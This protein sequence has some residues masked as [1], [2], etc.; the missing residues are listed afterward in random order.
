[1]ASGMKSQDMEAAGRDRTTLIALFLIVVVLAIAVG[2]LAWWLRREQDRPLFSEGGV[3][4]AIAPLHPDVMAP[5]PHEAPA[6]AAKAVAAPAK[7][8]TLT[9][10]MAPKPAGTAKTA[11]KSAK[12]APTETAVAPLANAIVLKPAPAD[13]A[14]TS[15]GNA[16]ALISAPDP[17]LIEHGKYGF[18]PVVGH[19]GRL[20]WQVYARPFDLSDPRPRIA[21]VVTGLGIG[22]TATDAAINRLPPEVTLAFAPF[23]P[24]ISEWTNLAR[25]AGHE[26]L[27]EVPMEPVDYPRQD[28]GY[29]ALL[30][31]YDAPE[32]L[33]RLEWAM[34]QT[35]GYVGIIG[36]M[37][38]RFQA[39]HDSLAPVLKEIATRGLLYVDNHTTAA[40]AV[41]SIAAGDRLPL[42][43]ANR[44]IDAEPA[45][46]A[47]DRNLADLEDIAK[48]D[49]VALGLVSAEPVSLDS[50]S[51]WA[52]GL[53]ARG[54][55]LAPVSAIV[56]VPQPSAQN[57]QPTQ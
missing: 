17:G 49:H 56:A 46:A 57:G 5:M 51:D 43:E 36:R 50:I 48:R 31:A 30:T 42:A 6:Q 24:R 3:S 53:A 13:A 32:N 52:A 18:L 14:P 22:S 26:V 41:S 21:I 35:V 55:A 15:A 12:P 28:P 1:M 27:L 8:A 23:S 33:D 20:P 47:L 34:S 25:V 40:S 4:V 19:D 45:R 37:G 9:A 10:A 16:H 38:G 11:A 2:S 7:P 29:N 54:I 39:A 44:V